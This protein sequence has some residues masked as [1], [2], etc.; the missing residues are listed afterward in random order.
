MLPKARGG[1]SLFSMGRGVAGG[2]V[3]DDRPH[4][5]LSLQETRGDTGIEV[6]AGKHRLQK[7]PLIRAFVVWAGHSCYLRG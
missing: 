7:I 5:P 3:V 6:Q 2:F 1:D 4:C